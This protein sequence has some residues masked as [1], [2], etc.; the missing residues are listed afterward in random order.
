[1]AKAK[2]TKKKAK[3]RL[4]RE[5][6]KQDSYQDYPVY[7][8]QFDFG[9]SWK[10]SQLDSEIERLSSLPF[11]EFNQELRE[12]IEREIAKGNKE[13]LK[14]IQETFRVDA[15]EI[16]FLEAD[17]ISDEAERKRVF[18]K[19]AQR[20][21]KHFAIQ[22]EYVKQLTD[23]ATVTTYQKITNFEKVTL[24]KWASV[25][26]ADQHNPIAAEY[27]DGLDRILRYYLQVGLYAEAGELTDFVLKKI[28]LQ[29]H[30]H[31]CLEL[32]LLASLNVAMD[33]R[34]LLDLYLGLDLAGYSVQMQQ[35]MQ[36]QILMAYLFISDWD[37]AQRFFIQMSDEDLTMAYIFATAGWENLLE[38]GLHISYPVGDTAIQLESLSLLLSNLKAKPLLVA[39]LTEM[40]EQYLKSKGLHV[41]Q[42]P[43]PLFKDKNLRELTKNWEDWIEI[44]KL[45]K[46]PAFKGIQER[47][48]RILYKQAGIRKVEDFQKKTHASI[49]SLPGIGPTTIK[50][51]LANGVKFKE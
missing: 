25:A 50:K 38:E 39:Y 30:Y 4:K 20:Y 48:V 33:Q 18:T 7:Q 2:Q 14:R 22:C 26:Y 43:V 3:A 49:L 27:I 36:V 17:Q 32:P 23:F 51:L 1:M 9:S 12:L 42:R 46:N 10:K 37:K 16:A 24:E 11:R 41:S 47:Y 15:D 40:A 34:R 21:P 5:Q 35:A 6:K 28:G 45:Q 19:L 13:G 44:L 29:D 8:T 31:N